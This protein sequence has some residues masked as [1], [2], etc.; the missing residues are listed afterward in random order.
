MR[1]CV[2]ARRRENRLHHHVLLFLVEGGIMRVGRVMLAEFRFFKRYMEREMM[3]EHRRA[4]WKP[5]AGIILTLYV[6]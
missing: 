3:H 4:T 5:I 6:H 2:D 1:R